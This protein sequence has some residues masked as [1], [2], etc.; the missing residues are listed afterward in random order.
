MYGLP[1]ARLPHMLHGG[2]IANAAR[3]LVT[4]YSKRACSI[5]SCFR[6]PAHPQNAVLSVRTFGTPNPYCP[7]DRP[8]WP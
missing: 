4:V 3:L 5:V 1:L 6:N 2:I 8:I 7:V